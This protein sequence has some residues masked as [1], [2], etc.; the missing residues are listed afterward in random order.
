MTSSRPRSLPLIQALRGLAALAVVLFHV[1]QLS[2]D[3]LHT[4]FFGEI[5]RF[6]WVGVDFFFVLSGFII[7]YSQWSRFGDRGWQSWRRFIIR[8]AVRI[9]PT[10]WVVMGGVLALLLLIPGLSGSGTITPWYI[11]Q[12]I[13]LLPQSEDPIL[14]VAWTLTLILFFYG[15]VSFAFLLPRRIYGIVVA[16]ILLGSLSQF[17]AAFTIPRS[18]ALPWIVFNSFHWEL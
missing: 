12:S 18:A 13:L 10:Y 11:V 9:Y 1:D 14:S 16:I 7:L 4:R 2:N 6:G 15:V 17:V 8:R 3:R 5:F